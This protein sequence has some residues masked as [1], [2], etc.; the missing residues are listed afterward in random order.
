MCHGLLPAIATLLGVSLAGLGV[1][2]CSAQIGR[3]LQEFLNKFDKLEETEDGQLIF[4]RADLDALVSFDEEGK[5]QMVFY[6]KPESDL[7]LK[8]AEDLVKENLGPRTT[9]MR[10]EESV[11]YHKLP[12]RDLIAQYTRG[13]LVVSTKD[14][15]SK[16]TS[17]PV[18]EKVLREA[19]SGDISAMHEMA[20]HYRGTREG[21]M[22]ELELAKK[23]DR[24][25]QTRIGWRYD[26]GDDVPKDE[27]IA[28]E[29]FTKAAEQ[30][31]EQ[32]SLILANYYV[33]G[34][35]VEKDLR[36]AKL[37]LS[38]PAESGAPIAQ[39][40]LGQIYIGEENFSEASHWISKAAEQGDSAAQAI[41][42][43]IYFDGKGVPKNF[44]T[45]YKWLI[46][47]AAQNHKTARDM[48]SYLE[49][50]LTASQ[51]AEGQ[52][53]A[54]EFIPNTSPRDRDQQSS[55]SKATTASGSGF[56]ITASGH[57]LTNQHVVRGG[58]KFTVTHKGGTADARL[59]KSNDSDD[60]A[61][62]KIDAPS[63]PLPLIPSS[64]VRMGEPV[65]TVG[66][67]NPSLQGK[68]P[69][70]ASG[71]VASLSGGQDDPRLFQISVPVQAG[72]SGGP[73]ADSYGN[74]VGIV[75]MKLNP[76]TSLAE[77][78]AMPE[79]V[80]YAVKSSYA[81]SLLESIPEVFSQLS[82]AKSRKLDR[83]GLIRSVTD[84]SVLIEVSR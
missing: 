14:F 8:E 12:D 19:E 28:A 41:L 36:K 3:P 78:G 26:R 84:A 5:A 80:N 83:D 35:G 53:R 15:H 69:K 9:S 67:P 63:T 32:A 79:N 44:S 43:S 76:I 7:S 81:L 40:M 29:W 52:R 61:L 68:R 27:S 33:H 45:A 58:R 47:A 30:G 73:L 31:D 71:E 13:I 59:L 60:L 34:T 16:P 65:I 72:N 46:L 22:W 51:L 70:L 11:L 54:A 21:L 48:L 50:Q 39:R 75:S 38:G 20:R 49:S 82:P 77:T 66:F 62:L 64:K 74:V 18:N 1:V 37:L 42:G 57:I 17:A 56:F 2:P 55:K 6:K 4:R 10:S 24:D 23:G 25:Y